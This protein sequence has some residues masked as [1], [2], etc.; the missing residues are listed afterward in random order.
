MTTAQP[1]GKTPVKFTVDASAENFFMI[2]AHYPDGR[3][4]VWGEQR[5]ERGVKSCI[6]RYAKQCRLTV[7][8]AANIADLTAS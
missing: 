6:T 7:N 4:M 5:T 2:V 1:L 8:K 3:R